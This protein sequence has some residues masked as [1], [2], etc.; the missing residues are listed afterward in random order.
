MQADRRS[1]YEQLLSDTKEEIARIEQQ[2]ETELAAIKERLHNLQ[3]EKKAQLVIYGGFCQLLGQ[4]NDLDAE[5]EE[6][7][8]E[9]EG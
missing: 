9:D 1:K 5:E 6:D 7:E 3:E 2:I 4:P 8:E